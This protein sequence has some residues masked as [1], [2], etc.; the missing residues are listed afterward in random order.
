MEYKVGQNSRQVLKYNMYM[1]QR[2][3]GRYFSKWKPSGIYEN[4]QNDP[5]PLKPN[6]KVPKYFSKFAQMTPP[7]TSNYFFKLLFVKNPV[8]MTPP[9]K[10][11]KCGPN[12]TFPP[13][14]SK[15]II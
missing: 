3:G 13:K 8:Q 1:T 11:L 10:K 12:L 4:W 6:R 5:P 9:P 7:L 2:G 14:T 15:I